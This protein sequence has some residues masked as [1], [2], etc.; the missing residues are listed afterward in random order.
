MENIKELISNP[1]FWFSSVIIAFLINVFAGFTKEW[2]SKTINRFFAKREAKAKARQKDFEEKVKWLKGKPSLIATY[3]ANIVYQKLRQ[4]LY[5]VV[6]YVSLL[7]GMH[8]VLNGALIAGMVLGIFS[9]F[10][11]LTFVRQVTINLDNL[12][13]VV[14][15]ALVDEKIHFRG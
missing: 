3:Q 6:I 4:V 13:A 15:A 9:L 5:L 12:K 2:I 10:I 14:N 1:A 7:L 8:N 11:L